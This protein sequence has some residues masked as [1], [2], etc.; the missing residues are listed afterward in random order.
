MNCTWH[1]GI[2]AQSNR[3]K[4]TAM[5]FN[6]AKMETNGVCVPITLQCVQGDRGKRTEEVHRRGKESKRDCT[7]VN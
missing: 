6:E 2:S 1:C 4:L 3:D 7:Q 5:S